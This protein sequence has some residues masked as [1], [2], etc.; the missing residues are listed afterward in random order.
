MQKPGVPWCT[1]TGSVLH[2]PFPLNGIYTIHVRRNASNHSPFAQS[3]HAESSSFPLN[4]ALSASVVLCPLPLHIHLRNDRLPGLR[5]LDFLKPVTNNAQDALVR[6]FDIWSIL[7][8]GVRQLA[9]MSSIG[10]VDGQQTFPLLTWIVMVI[11]RRVCHKR[12]V[13]SLVNASTQC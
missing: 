8:A 2:I 5:A 12:H 9:V 11:P 13:F 6:F 7:H 10:Q 1:Y 3:L 4:H